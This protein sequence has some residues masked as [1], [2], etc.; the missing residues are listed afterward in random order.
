V[1]TVLFIGIIPFAAIGVFESLRHWFLYPKIS[2]AIFQL[3]SRNNAY[4]D[5]RGGS[6]RSAALFA[7]PIVLG[8]MMIIISGLLIYIKSLTKN[9]RLITLA[10]IIIIACI[11]S[12]KTRGPWIGLVVMYT[13][14]LWLGK[15]GMRNIFS[16]ILGLAILLPLINLTNI[17]SKY[18]DMLPII[19]STRSDTIDYRVRLIENAWVVFQKNPLF[20]TTNFLET[21]EMESMR[22]GQGIIDLVNTFIQIVL[23][24]GALGLILFS[25]IFIS[26]IFR[27]YKTIKFLPENERDFIKIGKSLFAI[28]CGI[29][30]TISTV[31]SIGHIPVMYWTLIGV[32]AAY[33][34]ITRE[35]IIKSNILSQNTL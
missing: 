18:I 24:Y 11:L 27:C 15:S 12:T 6:L 9:D 7:S 14:Y 20:G 31:S 17:G 33:L 28:L 1:F 32:T 21:P 26:L 8:Y 10:F 30:F 35:I 23:P 16:F 25:A 2:E 19:G 5:V 4:I 34:H 3:A 22:Q 13:S 29:L